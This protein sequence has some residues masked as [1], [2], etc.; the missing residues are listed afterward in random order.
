MHSDIFELERSKANYSMGAF[1]VPKLVLVVVNGFK[2]DV[3]QFRW[4]AMV[5]TNKYFGFRLH[6]MNLCQPFMIWGVFFKD[7]V[8]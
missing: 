7:D 3:F 4:F 2:I 6:E 1:V 8:S 5:T